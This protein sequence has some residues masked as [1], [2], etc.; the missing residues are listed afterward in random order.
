M[1]FIIFLESAHENQAEN[2]LKKK[3]IDNPQETLYQLKELLG[4]KNK[5]YLPLAAVFYHPKRI[6]FKHIMQDFLSI[7]HLFTVNVSKGKAVIKYKDQTY[8]FDQD[9]KSWLEFEHFVHAIQAAMQERK[10]IAQSKKSRD[11]GKL[12][13][14]KNNI[15]IRLVRNAFEAMVLG[16][17]TD[18]CISQPGTPHFNNYRLQLG[19][20]TYFIFDKNFPAGHVLSLVVYMVDENGNVL[21]T[22]LKNNTGTIQNPYYEQTNR[23][24]Y[25]D[26]YKRYLEEHGIDIE[27]YLVSIPLS[28]K[29]KEIVEKFSQRTLTLEEFKQ[30][31]PQEKLGYI[32]IGHILNDDQVRYLV[33]WIEQHPYDY[34]HIKVLHQSMYYGKPLPKD[35]LPRLKKIKFNKTDL[36]KHYLDYRVQANNIYVDMH[37][38]YPL[39]NYEY[40]FLS[41]KQKEELKIDKRLL[42]QL[43]FKNGKLDAILLSKIFHDKP[44][45]FNRLNLTKNQW[46]E[47]AK[48]NNPDIQRLIFLYILSRDCNFIMDPVITDKHI[49]AW[50]PEFSKHNRIIV[51]L[52]EK[53]KQ[54]PNLEEE[55]LRFSVKD[56]KL[57]SLIISTEQM[58]IGGQQWK[59]RILSYFAEHHPDKL[60]FLTKELSI[61]NQQAYIESIKYFIQNN[62]F[63]ILRRYFH[64]AEYQ[65]TSNHEFFFVNELLDVLLEMGVLQWGWKELH[66]YLVQ[67]ASKSQSIGTMD[68]LENIDKLK[69]DIKTAAEFV[70][71]IIQFGWRWYYFTEGLNRLP[72]KEQLFNL[73]KNSGKVSPEQLEKLAKAMNLPY[74]S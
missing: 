27:R 6:N 14:K 8:T 65:E 70:I 3:N 2:I 20:T 41:N 33:D 60:L 28:E 29:E 35:L 66:N 13:I 56:P 47:L 48:I 16:R 26:E 30:L 9:D 72:Y 57:A 54:Y 17:G 45:I 4:P 25:T 37:A 5:K 58:L 18:F 31:S 59:K 15:E 71:D 50:L 24:D 74:P 44:E 11:A 1:K 52:L 53:V 40:D 51:C 7:S 23:G 68:L 49:K 21:L 22:D 42:N 10:L 36:L 64:W 39:K 63:D 34:P 69:I 67:L 46:K 62:Q 73:V 38:G 12:I 55:I 32:H 61:D 19:M 43:I